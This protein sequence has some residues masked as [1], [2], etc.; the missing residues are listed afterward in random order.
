MS[1][2]KVKSSANSMPHSSSL[3]TTPSSYKRNAYTIRPLSNSNTLQPNLPLT[4]SPMALFNS[5]LPYAHFHSPTRIMHYFPSRPTLPPQPSLQHYYPIT[6]PS[7]KACRPLRQQIFQSPCHDRPQVQSSLK[8]SPRK[9]SAEELSSD[10]LA[11]ESYL[12]SSESVLNNLSCFR[13]NQN[14]IEIDVSDHKTPFLATSSQHTCDDKPS[15]GSTCAAFYWPDG[16]TFSVPT[17]LLE[18][19]LEEDLRAM[20]Y[21]S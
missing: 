6:S 7:P 3:M 20:R 4:Y 12:N 18:R 13:E 8:H 9:H 19:R 2:P 14:C 15:T 5:Y 21:A 16:N 10:H 11:D 1:S 17:F